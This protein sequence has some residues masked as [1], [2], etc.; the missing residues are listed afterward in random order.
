MPHITLIG[1]G[2][3]GTALAIHLAK[4]GLNVCLWGRNA[5]KIKAIN[6]NKE[7]RQ[8]IPDVKIPD[9]VIITSDIDEAVNDME[10]LVLAVP[11][12]QTREVARQL[13]PYIR[14]NLPVIST[15]KGFELSTLKR[16]SE[17]LE[18]EL[19]DK[20]CRISILSGPSHAEEI[21]CGIPTAVIISS[22]EERTALTA[23]ELF[24]S[25]L[26]RVYT[27][28]DI[29]GVELAAGLKNVVA[30][31]VGVATGAGCGDNT[32][33]ALVTRGL[34]EISRLGI[35]C[36]ADPLTFMGLAGIGDLVVTC[37]SM[38]S[39]NLRAGILIGQGNNL[40]EA[41]KK[42]GMTVEG[43]I[44]T[45]AAKQLS[46]IHQVSMPICEELYSVLFEGKNPSDAVISLM[47]RQPKGEK[48][49][50]ALQNLLNI[51]LTQ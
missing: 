32:K 42:V 28:A 30:L 45:K 4:K 14:P 29:V 2:S 31:A 51:G 49:E 20:Q 44:A 3:M 43:V 22:K 34:A 10:A 18:E 17:V 23:Q 25:P 16:M 19:G 5:E 1:A 33:A 36:N 9:E 50:V 8:Y 26:F 11:S 6:D 15:A 41:L 21:S 12:D 46:E 47:M 13:K 40:D 35:A 24:I 7:N 27:N 38:H 39:R 48:E 37:M